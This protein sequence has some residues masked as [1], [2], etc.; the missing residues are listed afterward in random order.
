MAILILRTM[1]D[2]EHDWPYDKAVRYLTGKKV[3]YQDEWEYHMNSHISKASKELIDKHPPSKKAPIHAH[4]V[5]KLQDR[6]DYILVRSSQVTRYDGDC[7]LDIELGDFLYVEPSD[8]RSAIERLDDSWLGEGKMKRQMANLG[9]EEY[10]RYVEKVALHGQKAK[11]AVL[12]K[13]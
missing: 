13:V 3:G 9:D 7:I 11:Q 2:P 1:D 4:M 5:L 6:P 12:Q 10:E 8:Y